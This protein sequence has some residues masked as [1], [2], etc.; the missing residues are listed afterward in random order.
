MIYT[1]EEMKKEALKKLECLRD[2]ILDSIYYHVINACYL[3]KNYSAFIIKSTTPQALYF[4]NPVPNEKELCPKDKIFDMNIQID[5]KTE[6]IY[7]YL[8]SEI[9]RAFCEKNYT[10]APLLT[11]KNE[12]VGCVIFW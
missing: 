8:M 4:I 2:R 7:T 9:K 12:E 10:H 11:F 5:D 1:V 3:N 6:F